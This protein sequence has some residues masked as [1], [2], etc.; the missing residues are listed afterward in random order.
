[1]ISSCDRL[2]FVDTGVLSYEN[3]IQILQKP[4]LWTYNLLD[5]TVFDQFELPLTVFG[6][7]DGFSSLT[8]DGTCDDPYVYIP[9]H[10]DYTISVY[11]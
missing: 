10:F 7:P 2:Y 8:I 6:R 4:V 5:D 9:N 1:M 11:R 3:N